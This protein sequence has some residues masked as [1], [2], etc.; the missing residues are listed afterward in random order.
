M[1]PPDRAAIR[2]DAAGVASAVSVTERMRHPVCMFYRI[3][4]ANALVDRPRDRYLALALLL[5]V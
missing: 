3:V 1:A 5:I 4:G 2:P